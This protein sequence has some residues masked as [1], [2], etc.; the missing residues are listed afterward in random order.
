MCAIVDANVAHE[1]FGSDRPEA[2]VKFFE[3]INSGIGRL[4]AGGKLLEELNRTSAREWARQAL[5]AGLIRNVRET[6][7]NARMEELQN[8]RACR[9][10][11]P[12]IL[13]LAQISGARLLYSNDRNLQRDFSNRSLIGNP[14]GKIY[15]TDERR[16]PNREFKSAHRRL[17]GRKDL[18]RRA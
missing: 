2:G 7:V 10:N 17:L 12:H 1:V 9:S 13:A 6:D 3:W 11:D 18:C 5:N 15:S 16:N 4:V 8:E 14:P